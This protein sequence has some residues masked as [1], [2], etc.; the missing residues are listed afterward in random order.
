MLGAPDGLVNLN[1][2]V[3]IRRAVRP[4][5][6]KSFRPAQRRKSYLANSFLQTETDNPVVQGKRFEA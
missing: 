5:S 1:L 6:P 2:V 4:A 3:S